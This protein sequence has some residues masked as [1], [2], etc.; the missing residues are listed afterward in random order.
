MFVEIRKQFIN[1]LKEQTWMDS[2]T[3]DQAR[4]KVSKSQKFLDFDVLI[5]N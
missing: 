5:P 1:G 3:R 4:L 2:K